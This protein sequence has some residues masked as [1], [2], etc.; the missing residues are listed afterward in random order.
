MAK[1]VNLTQIYLYRMYEYSIKQLLRY[2][3]V[4]SCI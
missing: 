3:N 1:N 4:N 2:L